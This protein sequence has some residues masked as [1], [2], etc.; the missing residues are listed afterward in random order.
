M[1]VYLVVCGCLLLQL[2]RLLRGLY[3]FCILCI[4][5]FACL[6]GLLCLTYNSVGCVYTQYNGLFAVMLILFYF[7]CFVCG[8]LH[9]LFLLFVSCWLLVWYELLITDLVCSVLNCVWWFE[10]CFG[11]ILY[12]CNLYIL[13]LLLQIFLVIDLWFVFEG[14]FGV[15]I[16]QS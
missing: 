12:F 11:F 10:L 7:L 14:V 1:L 13:T 2:V 15:G 4:L 5:L 8:I 3:L 6:F 16:R 9:V